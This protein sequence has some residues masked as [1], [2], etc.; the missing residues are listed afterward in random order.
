MSLTRQNRNVT[1]PT[2]AS[3]ITLSASTRSDSEAM[4]LDA[5]DVNGSIQVKADNQGTPA[6][7][8]YVDVWIKWS[9]D[10]TT[11]DTDEHAEKLGRLNTY[12]TDDP[13]EDPAVRTFEINPGKAKYYKLSVA[14]PQA[15]SRN[16]VISAIEQTQRAA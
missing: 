15:A 8:D 11:Y 9:Q 10:G 6:S 1:W 16:V 13:G 2:A 3:S 5:T 4:T 7:G 12:G 14:A